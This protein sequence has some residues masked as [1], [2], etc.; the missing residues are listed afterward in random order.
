MSKPT[1]QEARQTVI[2]IVL[3]YVDVENYSLAEDVIR[4]RAAQYGTRKP[5]WLK[6]IEDFKTNRKNFPQSQRWAIMQ[7]VISAGYANL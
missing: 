2:E 6:T 5:K 7:W 4:T 3:G 1:L